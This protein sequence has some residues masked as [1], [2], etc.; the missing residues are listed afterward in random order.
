M[1]FTCTNT[2]DECMCAWYNDVYN[3]SG[4]KFYDKYSFA[5]KTNILI[6]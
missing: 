6:K 5:R 4:L 3:L 2:R 1:K